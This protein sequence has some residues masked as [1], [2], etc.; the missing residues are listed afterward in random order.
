MNVNPD[1]LRV[2]ET[3]LFLHAEIN[4]I[5]VRYG[6]TNG[7]YVHALHSFS[8]DS[9]TTYLTPAEVRL[10]IFVAEKSFVSYAKLFAIEE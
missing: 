2:G 8:W 3:Y 9:F 7:H 6:G 1:S 10:K 5:L 4:P